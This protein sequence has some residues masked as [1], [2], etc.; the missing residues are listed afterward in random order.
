MCKKSLL[1]LSIYLVETR[2]IHLR[3]WPKLSRRFYYQP[4]VTSPCLLRKLKIANYQQQHLPS[5]TMVVRGAHFK[6]NFNRLY[7]LKH[8]SNNFSQGFQKRQYCY[9][10][11]MPLYAQA[12]PTQPTY[13]LGFRLRGQSLR[14]E[15]VCLIK[16]LRR[17]LF[18]ELKN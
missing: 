13:R 12:L 2:E 9:D 11:T 8:I 4:N 17:V 1:L 7:W 16:K 10:R 14:I 18:L 15:G 6:K 5:T 3:L